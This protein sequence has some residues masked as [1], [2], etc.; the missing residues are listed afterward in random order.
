ML[1]RPVDPSLLK[2]GQD[3]GQLI[4]PAKVEFGDQQLEQPYHH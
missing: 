2:I 4:R 1:V 3:D